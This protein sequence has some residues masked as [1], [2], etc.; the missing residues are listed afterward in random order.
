MEDLDTKL[1]ARLRR[2]ILRLLQRE[3]PLTRTG[4]A[5]QV[6]P[7]SEY[8][9]T[10]LEDLIARGLVIKEAIIKPNNRAAVSY[11][12]PP[13]SV[14]TENDFNHLEPDE[15]SALVETYEVLNSTAVANG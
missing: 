6:R 4:L 10:V 9:D 15:V 5:V 13:I 14:Y 11:R 1:V 12:L 2:T 8:W 3:G 7:H